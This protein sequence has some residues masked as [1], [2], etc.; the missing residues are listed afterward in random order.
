MIM[1][2]KRHT[3]KPRKLWYIFSITMAL[4]FTFIFFGLSAHAADTP[5][6]WNGSTNYSK[7]NM[8]LVPSK[9]NS[10]QQYGAYFKYAGVSS[11]YTGPVVPGTNYYHNA[12]FNKDDY[13]ESNGISNLSENVTIKN[14]DSTKPMDVNLTVYLPNFWVN[15]STPWYSPQVKYA[16]NGPSTATSSN[17]ELTQKYY[18]GSGA[19]SSS[20]AAT[21]WADAKSITITG[22]LQPGH[23]Y[24]LKLPLV[25]PQI[26]NVYVYW[27]NLIFATAIVDHNNNN[28]YSQINGLFQKSEG[29]IADYMK[30]GQ[31][32]SIVTR[33]ING[34]LS[35]G[36]TN[37]KYDQAEDVQP[38]API[39]NVD[40]S[41]IQI[42]NGYGN[43][44]LDYMY[45]ATILGIDIS[46]LSTRDGSSSLIDYLY[47]NGYTLPKNP[48]G[49][50]HLQYVFAHYVTTPNQPVTPQP[51]A[52]VGNEIQ[53]IR[54]IDASDV[55]IPLNG[56]WNP[57]DHVKVWNP[58]N[59]T[60]EPVDTQPYQTTDALSNDQ[61]KSN[62]KVTGTVDTHKAGYY[63]VTYEYDVKYGTLSPAQTVKLKKTITVKV[64]NPQPTPTP[65]TPNNPTPTTPVTTPSSN[66]NWNP[67]TPNK[68]DGSTGL[69]NYA[70]T[71]GAAVYST[72]KIYMYKHATFKKSQRIAAY[73]KVK[74]INRHMFVII[75]YDRSNGG[76]LRYKVRD[77]NHGTK[78]AGKIGYITAN[79]KYVVN[80]YYKTMP[81]NKKITVISTNGIH[82]YK[83][84]NLSGKTKTYKK[85]THLKVKALI[86]HNLTT[87]YQLSNGYY[88]TANKKLVIHGNY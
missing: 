61:V 75:G 67:T 69:P 63:K 46:K 4:L 30:A 77:V 28:K 66:N 17:D 53:A 54:I 68:A 15:S 55:S 43:D 35:D 70:A 14:N 32:L 47:N 74:R 44:G 29:S 71:K 78:T 39:L 11:M 48:Y 80:V 65:V 3:I 2:I 26:K 23:Q 12:I 56:T 10:D 18:S 86:K 73:P 34:T 85:G 20:S 38:E 8:S 57:Y 24:N 51:R 49:N 6:I 27:D 76:A 5:A 25:V 21:D 41:Y 87:R 82:A 62:V 9:D 52:D 7:S 42:N 36:R 72:K 31:P 33:T 79:W 19:L 59:S 1:S 50:D 83:N 16:S 45:S 22:T 64:G 88:I 60:G 58:L 84:K 13:Q 37:Y 81:K 40:P